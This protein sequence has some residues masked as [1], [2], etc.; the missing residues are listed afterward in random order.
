M[1]ERKNGIILF[2]VNKKPSLKV[3]FDQKVYRFLSKYLLGSD[4]GQELVIVKL[5]KE[6]GNPSIRLISKNILWNNLR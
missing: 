6:M 5:N 3:I 1:N 2:D 4:C